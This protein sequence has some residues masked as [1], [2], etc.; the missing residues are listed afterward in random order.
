LNTKSNLTT[1][2]R[3]VILV[4]FYF[5]G[6]LLGKQA[7]FLSGSVALVWPPAGIAVAA[8]LLFGNRFWPGVALGAILFS[9]IDGVPFGFFTLGTAIGNTVGALVCSFLLTNLNGF[10]KSME[11]TRDVGGY[12]LLACFLGTTVNATF[13]VVGLAYS[14][15]VAW[16]HLFAEVANWWVPNAL[17]VLVVGPFILAWS[18]RS[19]V[20]WT[21]RLIIEAAVC[22]IG[23]VAGTLI[24]FDSWFVYGV[25]SYPLAYLPFPFL[26]WG[27]FRF[28]QKGATTGT[29]LV[30]TLAIYSLMRR[31]GPFLMNG[32]SES[33][34]LVGSYVGVLAVTSLLLAAA[35]CERRKA[36]WAA[37]ESEKRLRAVVEDQTD[38]ICRFEPDGTLSFVNGAFCRLNGKS[39]EELLGTNFLKSLSQEDIAVPLDFFGALPREQPVVAFDYRVVA[40]DG[41]EIWQQYTVRRLFSERGCR[42]EFQAVIQDITARKK[43]EDAL[44]HAKEAAEGANLAKSQFLA[45]MSHELRT[46]LNAIIGFSEILSDQTFG[47]LNE[48][49]FKYANHILSS[50]RHLLQLIN[51]ILDL[52]KIEAGRQEISRAPFNA[53]KALENLRAIV[54]TLASK[55]S[56]SLQ[57]E[58]EAELPALVA[59]EAKFKQIM[60]NLLSNAI[61]FTPDSGKVTV[62]TT[63]HDPDRH[64]C[65]PTG[66]AGRTGNWL[67]VEVIDTGIGIDPRDQDRIFVEFE[68]VDSSYGRQ[69]Q[70][71]GLGLALTRRLVEMHGGTVWVESAGTEGGGS[72]FIFLLPLAAVA[73]IP[74]EEG[75]LRPQVLVVSGN[76]RLQRAALTQLSA[77]GYSAGLAPD[78]AGLIEMARR[79]RPYAAVIDKQLVDELGEVGVE[80]LRSGLSTGLPLAAVQI[81]L[82]GKLEFLGLG[83][84]EPGEGTPRLADALRHT[85]PSGGKEVKTVLVVDDEPAL[86]ELLTRTLLFRGFHVL[87][88][89]D[90]K[91]G[92]ELA[93]TV[94]PDAIVLD[95]SLPEFNGLEVV[96]RLR[97]QPRTRSIPILIHTGTVLDEEER[98]RLAGQVQSICLK[99]EPGQLVANLERLERLETTAQPQTIQPGPN[100]CPTES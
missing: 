61:K 42:S 9:F 1:L 15:V 83:Q 24:S 11:R 80:T 79:K 56:I 67:R 65:G 89:L 41:T 50:G 86:L 92:F 96:E 82:D 87:N 48:R 58:T 64:T 62:R 55:K 81:D 8:L 77:V 100:L 45:N 31:R 36:E 46:P 99:T 59:D 25:Q 97:A 76:S 66:A 93:N 16:D 39:R 53:E 29:L 47:G 22:G 10:D 52:S 19:S 88:A 49:Q 75:G 21:P 51:D 3:V 95:L 35:A 54:R 98:Q 14:G 2:T 26:V 12:L 63:V 30:T 74:A 5:V 37:S 38:A 28:G 40:A 85:G 20:R 70:G 4:A 57:F 18:T 71:T 34:M 32:E 13:N 90:G 43:V 17:A 60:Y 73:K 23:L 27:A 78:P 94:L 69:Q 68:Q 44:Q 84:A 33:L 91:K 6:G 7:S 72:T